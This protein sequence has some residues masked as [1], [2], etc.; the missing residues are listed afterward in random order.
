[1]NVNL[2]RQPH[3]GSSFVPQQRKIQ[4]KAEKGSEK[5]REENPRKEPAAMAWRASLSRNVKE[6]RFLF[7]QSSPASA[8]AR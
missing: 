2:T 3:L 7:C 1:M 8:P 4:L 5:R 6:I